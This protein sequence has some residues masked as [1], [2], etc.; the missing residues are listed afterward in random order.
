MDGDTSPK[1]F[2][3]ALLLACIMK[4]HPVRDQT[5]LAETESACSSCLQYGEAILSREPT[6]DNLSWSIL[7]QKGPEMIPFRIRLFV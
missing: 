1:S 3:L 6:G 4:P 7:L 5:P 2:L